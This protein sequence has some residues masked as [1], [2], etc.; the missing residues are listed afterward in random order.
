M[1]RGA[2]RLA[3][4]TASLAAGGWVLRALHGAPAAL[5]A[6]IRLRSGRWPSDRRTFATVSFVNLDPASVQHRPRAT[7]TH[8]VGVDRLAAPAG[9]PAADIPL[10]T[11]EPRAFDGDASR[12]AVSW[13]G[14][15]TAL[16]EIDGYRV[17]T[18]PV[19]S[20]R[21]SPSDVVGPE[22]MHPPPVPL[23]ALPAV[24]AV[25]ISHDHYDHLDIDTIIAL[26]RSQWAPFVVP[27]GVGAHLRA[28]GIPEQRIIELDWNER[29]QVDELT[30]ICTPARH[31]SGRFLNRNNTL[32]ASWAFIGPAHRAYFG[33][34]TGYTKS[35]A[36]IGAEHG[37]FDLTLMPIGAYNTAWPDIHM[38]PEEAVQA[39]LDVTAGLGTAGADSLVHLP[40]GAAPVG[41]TDRAAAGRRGSRQRP[42]RGA[43]TG[44]ARG[45]DG[46]YGIRAVVAAGPPQETHDDLQRA[47]RQRKTELWRKLSGS[48]DVPLPPEKAWAHASD[49]SRF[50]EWLTIHRVW[51]S[52]L[53]EQLEKGTVIESIVEVMGMPNRIKWTIVHYKPPE[54]MTLN[55][56]GVGGVKVKLIAK[57]KPDRRRLGSQLRR[58]SRRPGPVRSDRHD[59]RRFAQG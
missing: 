10:V 6:P 25:V 39:H 41:R 14:H 26:A 28:W 40:V 16:V 1:M 12:L 15:S 44:W 24:D 34:D 37:P 35:F 29:T 47:E 51:R 19:W 53:P 32:W 36:E 5:G 20:D 48:I 50:K 49:L 31:F 38:N 18:D 7:A 13:F 56:I 27:L 30:L 57:V 54:S 9:R 4:G 23:E 58:T 17:L 43:A 2:L 33:G 22:R 45:S 8:R 46:V 3:A 59:G 52:K 42:G 21:C 55:G 11:P